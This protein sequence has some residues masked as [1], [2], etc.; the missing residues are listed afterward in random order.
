MFRGPL[1][2][3]TAN[4]PEALDDAM[5]RSCRIDYSLEY[6]YA[7]KYQTELIYNKI[8]PNQKDN[9]NNFYKLI[10]HK[11]YTPA[12]LQ[13]FLFYNRRCE[14]IIDMLEDFNKIIQK[15]YKKENKNI[16]N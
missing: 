13:E 4:N 1:L 8:L 11:Q 2:F 14:N 15:D 10:K 12:M 3:L 6:T 9:F 7:D 16:Y 5:L